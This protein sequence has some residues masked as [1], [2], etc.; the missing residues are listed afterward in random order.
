MLVI[1]ALARG[2]AERVACVLSYEWQ[3]TH[4]VTL[5]VFD[6]RAKSYPH[7]GRLVDLGVPLRRTRLMNAIGLFSRIVRLIGL[8]WRSR[9]GQIIAFMEGANLPV[10]VASCIC[11]MAKRTKVSVRN[12]PVSIRRRYRVLIPWLYRLPT[13]LV[14]PSDG[15]AQ[16]LIRRGVPSPR[17]VI[18]PNP[19]V[20]EAGEHQ[21]ASVPQPM[22][23]ILGVGRLVQQKQFELLIDAFSRIDA[24]GVCL[25]ILG[26]GPKRKC[27]EALATE[28]GVESRVLFR[29]VVSTIATWYQNAL[30]LVLTSRYEGWPNV[31]VEAMANGCPVISVNCRYGPSEI[32]QD[33]RYGLLVPQ[34]DADGLASAIGR[35]LS[36][37]GLRTRLAAE[38]IRRAKS[39]EAAKIARRWLA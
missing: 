16:A 33:G 28:L 31:L 7:G 34:G 18:I 24:P 20:E 37:P 6:A 10:I 22:R 17:V 13:C 21:R 38:G 27:L 3:R 15:I 32:L 36:D 1:G 23:Y 39:F 12:N 4:D 8:L 9:P 19:V 14:V 2:G 5:V 11:G 26:V 25:V 29:G 35:I 30:G